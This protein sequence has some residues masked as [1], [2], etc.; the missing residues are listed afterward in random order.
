VLGHD[1]DVRIFEAGYFAHICPSCLGVS[2][3]ING[4]NP[5][6]TAKD[7]GDWC[8]C[9][10]FFVLSCFDSVHYCRDFLLSCSLHHSCFLR[11]SPVNP[12]PSFSLLSVLSLTFDHSSHLLLYLFFDPVLGSL[13]LPLWLLSGIRATPSHLTLAAHVVGGF[14]LH[15][16]AQTVLNIQG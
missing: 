1:N 15:L 4:E 10:L 3:N 16:P 11:H 7:G 14:S 12:H 8:G 13:P 5:N 9:A 6:H 2:I